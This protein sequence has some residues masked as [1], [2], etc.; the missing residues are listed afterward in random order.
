MIGISKSFSNDLVYKNTILSSNNI[1]YENNK[2]ILVSQ[3]KFSKKVNK[4]CI[5][6]HLQTSNT[7]INTKYFIS[8]SF[9]PTKD[10]YIIEKVD[11]LV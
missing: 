2:W 10:Q 9:F 1:V 5:L 3:S 11:K 4:K 7:N 6:Y 8:K